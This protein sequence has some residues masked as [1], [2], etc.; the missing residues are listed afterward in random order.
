M[1]DFKADD[2]MT[3]ASNH[4][5]GD[6]FNYHSTSAPFYFVTSEKTAQKCLSLAGF[7]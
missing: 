5:G 4:A 2:Q 7:T 1:S 6:F 3:S